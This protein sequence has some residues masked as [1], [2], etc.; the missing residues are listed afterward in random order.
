MSENSVFTTLDHQLRLNQLIDVIDEQLDPVLFA[1][2]SLATMRSTAAQLPRVNPLLFELRLS[3]DEP[4]IDLSV[5]L[6]DELLADRSDWCS[7]APWCQIVA[8]KRACQ[9]NGEFAGAI[10]PQVFWGE[11]DCDRVYT[12]PIPGIF[13]DVS[14]E[15][16]QPENKPKFARIVCRAWDILMAKALPEST[17]TGVKTALAALPDGVCSTHFGI[18]LPRL[19]NGTILPNS[20]RLHTSLW[21]VGDIASWLKVV[22]AGAVESEV[23]RV[24]QEIPHLLQ[25]AIVTVDVDAAVGPRVGIEC[26]PTALET[27]S[28][29]LDGSRWLEKFTDWLMMRSL[30]SPSKA[31]ALLAWDTQ[32]PLKPA[33]HFYSSCD[34]CLSHL[35]LVFEPRTGLQAKAYLLANFAREG[36]AEMRKFPALESFNRIWES[37]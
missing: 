21:Q 17:I 18:M 25:H 33:A 7:T 20:L 35:K 8:L 30:A 13:F 16:G 36:Q 28:S 34:L 4:C 27:V 10:A 29:D 24:A 2:E 32:I 19:L 12:I 15:L 14:H 5:P 6:T 26:Y 37:P 11:F 9:I 22:G 1:P 31:Q 23:E 3:D